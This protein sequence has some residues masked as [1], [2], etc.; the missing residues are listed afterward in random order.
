[1]KTFTVAC[2]QNCASDDMTATLSAV[3]VLCRQ[4]HDN[5]AELLC[6][7]EYFSCLHVSAAGFEIGAQAEITHPGV[8]A[9][10]QLAA[11]LGVWILLGSVAVTGRDG[12]LFNRSILVDASGEITARYDKIHLFDVDL[13]NGESYRE[14][15]TLA[16]GEQAV[17]ADTPWGPMG[18]SICYDLRFAQL[19]RALA[20]A[21]ALFLTVPAAFMKTTG[22]AHWHVLLRARAIETGCYVFAPCQYGS[23]GT[24]NTFGHSLIVD[25]WG[26]VVADAGDG[27][28][29]ALATVDIGK[30]EAAR[31]MVPALR[32]DR[33]FTLCDSQPK[34]HSVSA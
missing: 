12:K 14:S 1:M 13:A 26:E 10:T 23:H 2:I 8:G 27:P 20:H 11:D 21:G 31:R 16:P 25:P 24:A 5:G 6:L 29:Y 4:A 28:G 18:L 22:Q 7:P 9:L 34:I 30:V 15:D 3:D 32:H 19:Y 17:V 33:N